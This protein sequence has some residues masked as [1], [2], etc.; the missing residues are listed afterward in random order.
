MLSSRT[1]DACLDWVIF[2]VLLFIQ[3]AA[4][5]YCQ[6]RQG[7][8]DLDWKVVH[9]VVLLFCVVAGF[10]RQVLR[11]HP[12]ESLVL[13]LLPEIFTNILLAMVMFGSLLAAYEALI[14]LTLLLFLIGSIAAIQMAL[15]DREI[16]P[17]DYKRLREDDDEETSDEEWV[18]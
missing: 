16:A 3:F 13:L 12:Y 10:Y 8:F 1:A 7:V 17:E 2:P 15:Q 11:R 4:T 5:M 14:V 6:M 18:C 9:A